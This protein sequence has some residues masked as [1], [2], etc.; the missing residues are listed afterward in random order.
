MKSIIIEKRVVE[1]EYAIKGVEAIID[2]KTLGRIFVCKGFGGLG[3]L[4]GGAMRWEHGIAIK[5][6]SSDTFAELEKEDALYNAKH[7]YGQDREVMQLD[8]LHLEKIARS[9]GI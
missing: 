1:C 2:H 8:G 6:R 5:L 9:V 7:G 4:R 3:E